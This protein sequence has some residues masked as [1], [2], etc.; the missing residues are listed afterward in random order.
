MWCCFWHRPP[1]E[2]QSSQAFQNVPQDTPE[3]EFKQDLKM[4]E[5][6]QLPLSK[7]MIIAPEEVET[8]IEAVLKVHDGIDRNVL[9]TTQ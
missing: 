6:D 7:T 5:D 4:P 3:E 2:D 1:L 8:E 9:L